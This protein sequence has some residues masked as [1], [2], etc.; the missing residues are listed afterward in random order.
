MSPRKGAVRGFVG[1]VGDRCVLS[2]RDLFDNAEGLEL[3]KGATDAD[4]EH[5]PVRNPNF[6]GAKVYKVLL[7]AW[8]ALE[9]PLSRALRGAGCSKYAASTSGRRLIVTGHGLGASLGA[10][11]AFQLADGTG[12][13][14]GTFGIEASFQFG[15]SR[16]GNPAF[17][18]AF[19]YKFNDAIFRVTHGQDPYVQYPKHSEQGFTHSGNE[20]HFKGD[21][22]WDQSHSTSYTRCAWNGEDPNCG[23]LN[24]PGPTSD[25]TKY[26]QPLMD[27]DMS[28]VSCKTKASVIV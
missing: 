19:R 27:A 6:R 17:V 7:R 13:Q 24:P 1:Q 9:I 10:L 21:A 28:A 2:L 14:E 26:M 5:L 18:K 23:H 25:H 4:L 15:A 3:I 12:Y 8:E 11:A 20:L 16:V 22:A